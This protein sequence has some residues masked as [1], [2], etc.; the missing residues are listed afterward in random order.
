MP[1][2]APDRSCPRLQAVAASHNRRLD[3]KKHIILIF[4]FLFWASASPAQTTSD[5]SESE[6][7]EWVF[8][9]L[10][11]PTYYWVSHA[12]SPRAAEYQFL[13]SSFGGILQTEYDPLPQR[14]S[15]DTN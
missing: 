1:S 10:I 4:I 12:G 11:G 14:F 2:V 6:P 3:M 13:D 15:L 5:S 9:G 7:Q 8:N